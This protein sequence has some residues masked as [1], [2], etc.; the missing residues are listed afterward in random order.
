MEAKAMAF[1]NSSLIAIQD[2]LAQK[3]I[4]MVGIS[5]AP[6]DFSVSLFQELIGRGYDIVPVNP[7]TPNVLGHT[8]FA[9]VQDIE[10]PVDGALV[11]TSCKATPG[12]VNDCYEAGIRRIWM[13]RAG[14]KGAVD[15]NAVA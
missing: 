11:M 4:A 15:E 9:R 8:C 14:G 13:Y 10:P 12:I 2:F 6:K 7:K 3:R 5:R 1:Q